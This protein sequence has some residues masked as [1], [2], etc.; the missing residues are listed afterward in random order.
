[1][2]RIAKVLQSANLGNV[3]LENEDVRLVGGSSER[4][5]RVE[6]CI[7]HQWGSICD[8]QWSNHDAQVVCRQLSF[9][10]NG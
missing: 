4:E 6:V 10:S 7:S 9:P 5:G 1:M 3:C 8:Q 2:T